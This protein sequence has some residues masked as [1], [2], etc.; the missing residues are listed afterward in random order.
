MTLRQAL[1]RRRH[2]AL[3]K[4]AVPEPV[5]DYLSAPLPDVNADWRRTR[6]L[7]LDIETTG[8]DPKSDAMLS[9][10]WVG[11]ANGQ[12]LLETAET[13]LVKPDTDVGQSAAVHGLTDTLVGEGLPESVVLQKVVTALK[14]RVLLVHYAGLDKGLI[15]R[16][17]REQYGLVLPMYVTDTLALE[18]KRQRS[19]HH[20]AP[21]REL[22]LAQ[23]R[24]QYSL[25]AYNAHDCLIDALATAELFLAM[26]AHR[27]NRAPVLLKELLS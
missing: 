16:L 5:A 25:P 10:G 3:R 7:A 24:E 1:V 9:V 8:L 26:A 2:S 22:R 17:C 27:E 18:I 13:W 14:G 19:Q 20:T 23:L 21:N 6:F 12:V 4:K 15:D 11:I